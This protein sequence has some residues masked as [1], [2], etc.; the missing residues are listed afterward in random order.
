MNQSYSTNELETFLTIENVLSQKSVH[1]VKIKHLVCIKGL[2]ETYKGFPPLIFFLPEFHFAIIAG[3]NCIC[4]LFRLVP[5]PAG[6]VHIG[7][8][9]RLRPA[10]AHR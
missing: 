5:P 3:N 6:S 4:I 9:Y 10:E 7:A 1:F 2:F 8:S